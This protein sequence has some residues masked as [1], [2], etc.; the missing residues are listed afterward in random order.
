MI[1]TCMA[2]THEFGRIIRSQHRTRVE[3]S[4]EAA[5]A[6]D[7]TSGAYRC[8]LTPKVFASGLRGRGSGNEDADGGCEP[9]SGLNPGRVA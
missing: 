8:T 1:P 3:A 9:R 6:G 7:T 4:P 5:D 2:G